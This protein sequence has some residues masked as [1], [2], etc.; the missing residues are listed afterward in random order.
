MKHRDHSHRV[1]PAPCDWIT[2]L[3]AT[4]PATPSGKG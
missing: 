3:A 2:L 4:A 1:T